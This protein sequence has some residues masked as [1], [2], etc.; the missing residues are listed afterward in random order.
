MFRVLVLLTVSFGVPLGLP[1][2][3]VSSIFSH[4]FLFSQGDGPFLATFLRLLSSYSSMPE[5]GASRRE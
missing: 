1:V 2:D 3:H 4:V 5:A